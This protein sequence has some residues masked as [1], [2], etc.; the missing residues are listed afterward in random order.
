MYKDLRS[1]RDNL[2][3]DFL[4]RGQTDAVPLRHL[5]CLIG[6]DGRTVRRMIEQERRAGTPI[7]SDNLTGYFL[8]ADDGEVERFCRSMRGRANEILRAAE[9]VERGARGDI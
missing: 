6:L 8:P 2:I 7:L 4:S 9:A 1:K 5:S 3:S